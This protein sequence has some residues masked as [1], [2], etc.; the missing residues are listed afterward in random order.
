[1]ANGCTETATHFVA[2][3]GVPHSSRHVYTDKRRLRTFI[4]RKYR[5]WMA[6]AGNASQYVAAQGVPPDVIQ[7]WDNNRRGLPPAR[8]QYNQDAEA[9]IW[10]FAGMG[11]EMASEGCQEI[12]NDACRAWGITRRHLRVRPLREPGWVKGARQRIQAPQHS[13]RNGGEAY[14]SLGGGIF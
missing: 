4:E 11:H 2:A 1:M 3:Y 5:Y 14:Y 10:K 12:F 9:I 8:L 7:W 6:R 13:V